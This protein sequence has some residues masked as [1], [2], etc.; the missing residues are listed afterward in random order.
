VAVERRSLGDY[1]GCVGRER[2]RFD[3]ESAESSRTKHGPS[4]WR[5]PAADE[6]IVDVSVADGGGITITDPATGQ[7]RVG[8]M[9][10]AVDPRA[11]RQGVRAYGKGIRASNILHYQRLKHNI[12]E[13][14]LQGFERV[15]KAGG[16]FAKRFEIK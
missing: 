15:V 9:I 11:M 12:D 1:I 7:F 6:T 3:R 8:A 5:D 14:D 10:T 4:S 2:E 16:E 13:S